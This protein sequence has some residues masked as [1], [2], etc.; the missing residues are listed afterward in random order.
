MLLFGAIPEWI[1]TWLTPVW[2]MGVGALLGLA[3]LFVL[4]L[5]LAVV[6]KR[7]AVSAPT[8]I[9]EGPMLP[10][11]WVVLASALFGIIG[12]FVATERSELISSVMRL[13]RVG[14]YYRTI[15]I[16]RNRS[17]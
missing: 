13:P 8:T 2:L 10:V 11:F 4:W 7:A 9:S 16:I 15:S 12:A 14:Q 17:R 3:V 6:A 1:S 5:L